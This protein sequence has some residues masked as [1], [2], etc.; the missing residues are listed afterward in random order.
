MIGTNRDA[1]EMGRTA[2]AR[3]DVAERQLAMLVRM[4]PDAILLARADRI[5]FANA[6]AAE[7]FG[8]PSPEDLL[9]HSALHWI[10]E[11]DRGRIR[12]RIQRLLGKEDMLPRHQFTVV[13]SDGSTRRV[14]G[15]SARF[16][17][18]RGPA[19]QV[20]LRDV[21][22][23]ERL[24]R[25]LKEA[26]L[27]LSET[28]E[29]ITDAFF[30][31]DAAWRLT[32]VNRRTEESWG[33][34][35]DTLVG[36]VLWELFPDS[37]DHPGALALQRAMQER[38]PVS[39]EAFSS[40]LR[41]WVETFAYPSAS[42]G[43]SVYFRDITERYTLQARLA[44]LVESLP[45][46][47]WTADAAGR[48]DWFNQRWRD[49]TGQAPGAEA[50]ELAIHPDDR[51]AVLAMWHRSVERQSDFELEH[52]LRRA[53]GEYRWHLR[54]AF[55]LRDPDGRVSQWFGTCTDI[56]DLKTS[57]ELLRQADR[58]KEDFLHM[59]AH[60]FRA[61]LTAVRL[62][63]DL[64]RRNLRS[65]APALK[66]ADHQ[67]GVV[68]TQVDRIQ[69][70]LGTLLDVSQINT[71]R[72]TLDLVE[73]DLAQLAGEVVERFMPEAVGCSTALHLEAHPVV[74][75]WDRGRLDQ[76][77]ANLVGNAIKYGNRK[78][79]DVL[80]E[81]R[82][83]AAVLSVT[84]HGF[85][86]APEDQARIFDRFERAA[87]GMPIKGLGLGLWIARTMVEA[88]GGRLEVLSAPGQGSTF[89]V[90]LPRGVR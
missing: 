53:D 29:S 33:R 61:P 1:A 47:V 73:M 63:V 59:A 34:P 8:V 71:G 69:A 46:L 57:A 54:R 26:N 81:E 11:D 42:G 12:E 85:G 7:L 18:G 82:G 36:R 10:H 4:S 84:D 32:Y 88:H 45:Q 56:H 31:V 22:E 55:P 51:E 64:L 35:R 72:L 49:Y 86:I 5:E 39:V 15:T 27:R 62:Q 3:G 6:A 78:P 9:G 70:L 74:G 25:E 66:R 48:L 65:E 21:T 58:L 23:R 89:T 14:E 52:R 79:V 83:G 28:I 80:V 68:D 20:V 90:T 19:I 24:D 75:C 60:E 17:D 44:H 43:L 16:D 77:I 41:R 30:V 50:W 37:G 2:L 40:V 76:V 38:R 13:R 67:L 87:G